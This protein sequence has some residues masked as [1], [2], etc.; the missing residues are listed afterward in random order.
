V[1]KID[2]DPSSELRQIIDGLGQSY[3]FVVI[4]NLDKA[5]E[6]EF[7]CQMGM[8]RGKLIVE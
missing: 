6:F 4:D 1:L 7:Q 2:D 3:D 8:L 5:G